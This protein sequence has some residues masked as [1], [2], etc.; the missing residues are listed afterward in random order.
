MD[1]LPSKTVQHQRDRNQ[2]QH[3]EPGAKFCAIA[4]QNAE[5][6]GDGYHAR[7]WNRDRGQGTP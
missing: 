3:D 1:R 4:Q 6:A 5:A 7:K 2:E